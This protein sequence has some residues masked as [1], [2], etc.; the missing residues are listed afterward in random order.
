MSSMDGFCSLTILPEHTLGQAVSL[1][2]EQEAEEAEAGGDAE[3]AEAPAAPE[4]RPQAAVSPAE[5]KVRGREDE[6]V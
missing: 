6:V 4:E 1:G 3:A 2:A 5:P